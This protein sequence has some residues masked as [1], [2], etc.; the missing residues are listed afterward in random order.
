[1]QLRDTLDLRVNGG[2]VMYGSATLP[3]TF[4][5]LKL[6]KLAE[7]FEVRRETHAQGGDVRLLRRDDF[8][9]RLHTLVGV[10]VRA[11]FVLDHGGEEEL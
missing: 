6:D 4:R 11:S 10:K 2:E 1:M 9:E 7:R 8:A 5:P 3:A